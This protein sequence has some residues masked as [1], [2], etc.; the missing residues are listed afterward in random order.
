MPLSALEAINTLQLRVRD[1]Q[2]SAH[3][4]TLVLDLLS[5]CQQI[6]NDA[7]KLVIDETTLTT[8]PY[9]NFYTIDTLLPS[10]LSILSVKDGNSDLQKLSSLDDLKAISWN[11]HRQID[12]KH[13]CWLQLGETQLV[14]WPAK[15]YESS[16]TIV[17]TQ[18]T[19]VLTSFQQDTLAISTEKTPF[20]L[21]LVEAILLMRQR[22]LEHASQKLDMLLQTLGISK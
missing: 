5:R 13:H 2:G 7:L 21:D 6:L 17:S 3:S 22:D 11:W 19:P 18:L 4:N 16:V 1:P 8:I 10:T 14:L 9:Q 20:L 15:D 12:A